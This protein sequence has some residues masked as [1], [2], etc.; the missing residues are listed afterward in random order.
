MQDPSV[1]SRLERGGIA[2]GAWLF[3]GSPR[4]AEA[5]SSTALDWIAIDMEHAP[6][7]PERMESLV[8]AIAPKASPI[9]RLPSVDAAIAGG[10]KHALDT[11]AEGIIV[12]GVETEADAK[13]VVEACKIPP[14]GS[15]GVAGTTRAN[16]Y[17]N[18]FQ[19]HWKSANERTFLTVQIESKTGIDNVEEIFSVPGVDVGFVGE[20]DLAASLDV[21]GEKDHPD[22]KASVDEVLRAALNNNV[23]PGI[24]GR[25]PQLLNERI[26]RGFQFFLL[27]ADV[28]FMRTA[29]EDF[30]AGVDDP[31][32]RSP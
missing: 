1:Q 14:L 8:R 25:T 30:T 28:K 20:N 12:P 15:R 21:L 27:G 3:S 22:V 26:E 17:G 31:S 2:V 4:A 32:T 9:V 6:V 11:G 10:A 5:L 18:E 7:S 23:I 19:D 24:A 29:V 16:D 13:Q